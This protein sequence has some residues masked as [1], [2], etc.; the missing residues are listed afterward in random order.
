MHNGHCIPQCSERNAAPDNDNRLDGRTKRLAPRSP[1]GRAAAVL[2]MAAPRCLHRTSS[3]ALSRWRPLPAAGGE[4]EGPGRRIHV[5]SL[6]P[7]ACGSS[8]SW[9]L[10]GAT[11]A[12]LRRLRGAWLNTLDLH[13]PVCLGLAD[14]LGRPDIAEL[15]SPGCAQASS[16]CLCMRHATLFREQAVTQHKMIVVLPDYLRSGGIGAIWHRPI[17]AGSGAA[18]RPLRVKSARRSLHASGRGSP[19]TPKRVIKRAAVHAC[20]RQR[21]QGALQFWTRTVTIS[22]WL[23]R[24][25]TRGQLEL[26]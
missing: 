11:M 16:L 1:G 25:L 8:S 22:D 7:G 3:A 21:A 15:T 14:Y 5:P 6:W 9:A 2:D 26:P 18:S 23:S 13:P 17:S 10:A 4:W 20:D 24:Q 19:N 12:C